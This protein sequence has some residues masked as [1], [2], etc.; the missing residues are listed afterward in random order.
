[1]KLISVSRIITKVRR[2]DG[3]VFINTHWPQLGVKDKSGSRIRLV[4]FHSS[5][6]KCN[7][8]YTKPNQ[9]N[10]LK[11]KAGVSGKTSRF[12]GPGSPLPV[13]VSP[14]SSPTSDPNVA[15][16]RDKATRSILLRISQMLSNVKEIQH[17]YGITCYLA[18]KKIH[19]FH[20]AM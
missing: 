11:D 12:T 13:S 5:K 18:Q 7:D 10:R 6:K 17:T 2:Q 20:R 3:T 8:Y 19:I 4:R 9:R 1:M 15:R 14:S 16:R